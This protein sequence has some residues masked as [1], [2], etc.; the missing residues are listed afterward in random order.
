MHPFSTP[1]TLPSCHRV[2][3]GRGA[4]SSHSVIQTCYRQFRNL[5]ST[6]MHIFGLWE[7]ARLYLVLFYIVATLSLLLLQRSKGAKDH[8]RN[9]LR[10][11]KPLIIQGRLHLCPSHGHIFF[12]SFTANHCPPPPQGLK[13]LLLSVSLPFFCTLAAPTFSH[14]AHQAANEHHPSAGVGLKGVAD[15]Y[16]WLVHQ[17]AGWQHL[18]LFTRDASSWMLIASCKLSAM[19]CFS[20]RG[21]KSLGGVYHLEQ[22][23][24]MDM[25]TVWALR[26]LEH[27]CHAHKNE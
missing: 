18:S 27:I 6:Q 23:F 14:F 22:H 21:R 9:C 10:S 16:R 4:K 24:H 17:I 3:A 15:H 5:H 20:Y 19:G 7:E 11:T 8:L 1:G 26:R 2:K 13:C 12:F 25:D